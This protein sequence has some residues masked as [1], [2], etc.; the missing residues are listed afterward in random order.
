MC[1]FA[2]GPSVPLIHIQVFMPIPCCFDYCGF[3]VLSRGWKVYNST[4]DL[5]PQHCLGNSVSLLVPYTFCDYLFLFCKTC[6]E[7]FDRD[8][9]KSV[10][11]FEQYGY[12]NDINSSSPKAEDIFHFFVSSFNLF[13][14]YFIVLTFLAEFTCFPGGSVGEESTCNAGDAGDRGQISGSGRS[15]EEGMAIHSSTLAWRIPQIEEPGGLQSIGLQSI[16]SQ[17]VAHD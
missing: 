6:H 14:Q 4:F 8:H 10:N 2:F 7:Y 17:R 3:V 15:P 1:G 9:I 12:F 13:Y 5:F 16:G 11:C